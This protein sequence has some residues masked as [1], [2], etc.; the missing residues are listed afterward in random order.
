MDLKD[1]G[2]TQKELQSK[3]VDRIS[4]KLMT[5]DSC[6]ENGDLWVKSSEFKTALE[7]RIKEGIDAAI[8]KLAEEHLLPNVAKQV[9]EMCL[10][11]T[12]EWGEK[13]GEPLSFTEYLIA[14][15]ERYL[16][17]K[18]DYD[19]N[20]KSEK[21]GY[22][23]SGTQ[24]RITHLVEK[25]LHYKIESAMKKAVQEAND[26]I[27]KGITETVKIKLAEINAKLKITVK[28]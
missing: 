2:F 21:G 9:E 16:A 19:G 24:T 4:E 8:N 7:T 11:S 5:R 13:K 17:E 25:H 26:V 18:V 6:D 15:A 14:R 22:S 10:Q 20:S 27:T 1:L 28:T 12:N 3:V 23:W